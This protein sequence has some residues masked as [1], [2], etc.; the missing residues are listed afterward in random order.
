MDRAAAWREFGKLC[1]SDQ[2]YAILHAAVYASACK[3]HGI[4]FPRHPATWLRAR[5]FE[6]D[7]VNAVAAAKA[8]SVGVSKAQVF[9]AFGTP[10]FDAW[11]KA[12]HKRTLTSREDASGKTGWW[13]LSLFPPEQAMAAE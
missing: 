6:F 12:G 10:A 2:E 11:V 13:F 3:R 7:K 5:E 8:E 4:Q 1:L 9:V